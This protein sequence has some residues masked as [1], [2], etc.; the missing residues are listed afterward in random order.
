ME[1]NL[2]QWPGLILSSSTAGL[3]PEGALLRLCWLSSASNKFTDKYVLNN[4]VF[5]EV[6]G[7]LVLVNSVVIFGAVRKGWDRV[8]THQV[9][10]PVITAHPSRACVLLKMLL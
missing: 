8:M 2:N 3:L 6:D 4:C 1:H 7:T 9:S 5:E 10:V